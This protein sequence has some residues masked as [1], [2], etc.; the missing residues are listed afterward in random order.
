MYLTIGS[1]AVDTVTMI[2]SIDRPSPVCVE[3]QLVIF[4]LSVLFLCRKYK[5]TCMF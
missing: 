1:N 2:Y 3:S 4:S 5:A